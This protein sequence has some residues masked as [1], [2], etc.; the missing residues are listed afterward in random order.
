MAALE[1]GSAWWL[2]PKVVEPCMM[3][4]FGVMT[5]VNHI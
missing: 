3:H 2:Q 4:F 1:V 5:G